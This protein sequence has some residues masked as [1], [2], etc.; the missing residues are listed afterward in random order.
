MRVSSIAVT[1]LL[2]LSTHV[3]ASEP[4]GPNR[5]FQP[6]AS[7]M[8]TVSQLLDAASLAHPTHATPDTLVAAARLTAETNATASTRSKKTEL[9]KSAS[10]EKPLEL[11]PAKL[12]DAAA[13]NATA[14]LAKHIALVKGAGLPAGK[15]GKTYYQVE[16]VAAGATDVFEISFKGGEPAQVGIAGLGEGDLDLRVF[17]EQWNEICAA[18]SDSAREYC[19]WVPATTGM[20]RIRVKNQSKA[21]EDYV[22][23]TN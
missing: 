3:L 11:D 18:T 22:F 23:A 7:G 20:F 6:S 17:D 14:D 21:N 8:S 4:R 9:G 2:L 13:R 1:S 16:R 15:R 5:L 19:S 10:V 12:L